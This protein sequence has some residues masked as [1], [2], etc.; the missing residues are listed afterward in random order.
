MGITNDDPFRNSSTIASACM[1]Y[2]QIKYLK[3]D[4]VALTPEAGYERC[5]RQ[6]SVALKYL[7]W[8]AKERGISIQTR[9]S[10]QGEYRFGSLRVDGFVRR[11][12]PER[13]LVIEVYGCQFHGC[14]YCLINRRTRCINGK[15]ADDN[16]TATLQRERLLQGE[17]DVERIWECQIHTKLR[18]DPAMRRFFD[19]ECHDTGPIS[20]R[21]A[22]YGGRTGPLAL[23]DR[24]TPGTQD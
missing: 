7:K 12:W 5:D 21:D 13:S 16:F 23:H 11:P 24:A 6:S 20:A 8:L 4:H 18:S 9:D 10:P 3:P 17:F 1:R 19:L 22:F 2:W 15:T 14:P